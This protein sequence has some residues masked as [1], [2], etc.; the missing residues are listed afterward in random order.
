VLLLKLTLTPILIAAA[1]LAARRWGPT[2]GGWFAGLP[3][4]SGPV[5]VFLALE[6]GRPFAATAARNSILGLIGVAAFGVAYSRAAL[7][8]GPFG[9]LAVGFTTYAI[10]TIASQAL[11]LGPWPTFALVCLVLVA[12]LLALPRARAPETPTAPPWW[13]LP[14]RIVAATT[15]VL[16][17]TTAAAKLGPTWSGLLSPFPVFS[18]VLA[19]FAHAMSGREAASRLQRGV[20]VGVFSFAAFFLVVALL[21]E[22]RSLPITYAAAT[23]TA[24]AINGASLIGLRQWQRS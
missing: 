14:F 15:M 11:H 19:A 6:Q 3:L 5:S 10:A 4:T 24:L 8:L 13:D 1:T 21:V 7:W 16:T 20:I 9:C 18:S 2:I 17:I 12:A 22:E 23:I